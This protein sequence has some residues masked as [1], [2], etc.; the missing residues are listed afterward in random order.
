MFHTCKY[1]S[2]NAV[3]FKTICITLSSYCDVLLFFKEY[4]CCSK[5]LCS[6]SNWHSNWSDKLN[7]TCYIALSWNILVGEVNW[8]SQELRPCIILVVIKQLLNIYCNIHI[9]KDV[10]SGLQFIK[11]LLY[12]PNCLVYWFCS[13]WA[14]ILRLISIFT[15]LFHLVFQCSNVSSC[16]P[17]ALLLLFN[18]F[19]INS[20]NIFI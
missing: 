7:N 13:T 9:Q 3:H 11:H 17:T 10:F 6:I 16:W 8:Q 2:C 18:N 20:I 4:C 19:D 14:S 1:F 15:T 5:S 12:I